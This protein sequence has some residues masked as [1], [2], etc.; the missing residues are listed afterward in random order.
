MLTRVVVISSVIESRFDKTSRK[1]DI[2]DKD[3]T[4]E[5][6]AIGKLLQRAK[7]SKTEF[8]RT[9]G[10]YQEFKTFA[11]L[12]ISCVVRN[13]S[14]KLNFSRVNLNKFVTIEDECLAMLILENNAEEWIEQVENSEGNKPAKKRRLTKYTGKGRKVDGTKKGWTLEGKRR[15]NVMFDQVLK[16]R[17]NVTS[18]QREENLMKDWSGEQTDRDLKLRAGAV[19]NNEQELQEEM[20]RM[21][22]EDEFIPRCS[23]GI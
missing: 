19:T 10:T 4:D 15:F 3:Q 23:I 13:D 2:F 20:K 6:A 11:E 8:V 12:C 18:K 5:R 14:W 1:L 7:D 16:D 17:E 9:D 21:R 22:E